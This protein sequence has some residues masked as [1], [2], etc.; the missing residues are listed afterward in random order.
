VKGPSGVTAKGRF[1]LKT[2][3]PFEHI[4]GHGSEVLLGSSLGL[5]VGALLG[6]A[7]G[8][9]LGLEVG[10]PVGLADG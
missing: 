7:D 5:S 8:L 4:V 10:E 9:L 3:A 2:C 6:I 1:G